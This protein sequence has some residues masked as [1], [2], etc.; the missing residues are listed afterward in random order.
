VTDTDGVA[1][2]SPTMGLTALRGQGLM[3]Q[4]GRRDR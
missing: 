1:V 4:D 2:M 3:Y